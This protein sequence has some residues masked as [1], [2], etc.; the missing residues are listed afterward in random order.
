MSMRSARSGAAKANE[1]AQII[2]QVK[3]GGRKY[4]CFM[5]EDLIF[6]H[7][8]ILPVVFTRDSLE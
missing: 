6:G 2:A 7:E 8:A 4:P 1:P 3:L 5:L